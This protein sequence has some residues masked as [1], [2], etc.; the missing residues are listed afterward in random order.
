M[1]ANR[2]HRHRVNFSMTS[3]GIV[4]CDVTYEEEG[5]TRT[6]VVKEAGLLLTEAMQIADKKTK[7]NG[8][9]E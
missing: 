1:E 3:K 6:E 2:T 9:K 5:S 7:E 8:G 4:S